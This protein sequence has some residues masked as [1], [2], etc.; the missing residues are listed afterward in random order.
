MEN[1]DMY[2]SF[3][4]GYLA[5]IIWSICFMLSGIKLEHLRTGFE[6]LGFRYKLIPKTF[7][8][9]ENNGKITEF[10]KYLY[11]FNIRLKPC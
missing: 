5:F 9:I 10:Y 3:T 7:Q 6:W 4:F 1:Y 8:P 2:L 11:W